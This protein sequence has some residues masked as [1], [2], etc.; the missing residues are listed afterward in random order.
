MRVLT[1]GSW[2]R[3]WAKVIPQI[4]W[5]F[6]GD[7]VPEVQPGDMEIMAHPLDYLGLNYYYLHVAHDP[8]GGDGPILYQRDDNNVSARGWE[9]YPEGLYQ[10]LVWLH[11]DYPQIPKIIVTENGTAWQ[12]VVARD[13]KVH[14]LKR[15]EFLAQH[16]AQALKAINEGVPLAG[17]FVWTLIDDFEWAFGTSSRFGLAYVDFSTQERLLKD[18]RHWFGCVARANALV[19]SV[20]E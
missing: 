18:S 12:D 4:A 10:S 14:D 1:S 19:D 13:G 11:E 3:S 8:A 2:I 5:E 20:G 7:N 15:L 16:L 17:Y 6:Y 9:V